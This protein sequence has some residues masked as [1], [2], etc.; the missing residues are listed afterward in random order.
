MPWRGRITTSIAPGRAGSPA[1]TAAAT[2]EVARFFGSAETG[3]FHRDGGTITYTGPAEWSYRRFILHYAHLCA[4][5]GGIDA[6][7]WQG[8]AFGMG[9]ERVT[10]LKYGI[11]DLRMF[12]ENDL[13][14]LQQFA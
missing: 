11:G 12:F 4:A 8:F 10:M 14:F 7:Q 3:H 6:S 1:G 13:R 2:A 9:V 5:A